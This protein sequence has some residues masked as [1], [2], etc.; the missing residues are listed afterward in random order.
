MSNPELPAATRQ[1]YVNQAGRIRDSN[2]R[3]VEQMY[4]IELAW[5]SE[6]SSGA[7]DTTGTNSPAQPSSLGSGG[8]FGNVASQVANQTRGLAP[9]RQLVENP[10]G[11]LPDNYN[12]SGPDREAEERRRAL[13]QN[14]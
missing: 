1:Q 10:T 11:R 12:L 2:L 8:T 13:A 6:S 5:G 3:L 9:I 4:G 14:R 7:G